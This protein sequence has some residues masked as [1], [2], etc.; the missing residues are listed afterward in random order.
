MS[1]N[2]LGYNP[3]AGSSVTNKNLGGKKGD[4]AAK[5][6]PKGPIIGVDSN[7]EGGGV[8]AQTNAKREKLGELK[9]ELK[10]DQGQRSL[11]DA[12]TPD[13]KLDL[14]LV[15]G[16]TAVASLVDGT[17]AMNVDVSISGVNGEEGSA[18]LEM[19]AL[20]SFLIL[21]EEFEESLG[22]NGGEPV[23]IDRQQFESHLSNLLTHVEQ[24]RNHHV[25]APP[26]QDESS[27][28]AEPSITE[29]ARTPSSLI[30][31]RD[32]MA[33]IPP[34][35]TDNGGKKNQ[36]M[37]NHLEK[38]LFEP[39]SQP[40]HECTEYFRILLLQSF[41]DSL[42]TKWDTIVKISDADMDRAA[43]T[44]DILAPS[45][46]ISLHDLHEALRAFIQGSNSARV[47]ALW[48]LIDKD[49]DGLLDQVEMDEVVH[50]SIAIV[51]DA[52]QNFVK[53]CVEVWPMRGPLPGDELLD[54]DEQ[55]KE[56]GRYQKWKEKRK[57]KK[58]KKIVLK[59]LTKAVKRHFEIDVEVPH[60][61]R[62]CYA[63]AEK[64]HQDGKVQSVLVDNQ[65]TGGGPASVKEGG[66]GGFLSG[67]RK[68]YVELD[69]K[70][71]YQEFKDVQQDHFSHLDKVGE[72][73]CTSLK[74]EIW[75]Q[76]GK[77]R[78]NAEVKRESA[79][80]LAVVSLL[81]FGIYLS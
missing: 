17:D 62:C 11:D 42:S 50:M 52:L 59:L 29:A 38:D 58:P 6:K 43:T 12:A 73:L 28:D 75:I 64:K 63:W 39:T 22:G 10:F 32:I 40:L 65:G 8:W 46:T 77:G 57:E 3:M 60:R 47:E 56:K 79:A 45:T 68:R 19:S 27:E 9:L 81:D 48:N 35:N 80:F 71:N 34:D 5:E 26:M 2:L 76:Q 69:P 78:Q 15:D 21:L 37:P 72:E 14:F 67:G 51:E 16:I 49:N 44:G 41:I 55:G 31:I 7:T 54:M 70:I 33:F 36:K 13:E 24:I 25:A 4:R 74:E 23:E 30:Y 66:G 53:D 1:D 61:L 18:T 20:K